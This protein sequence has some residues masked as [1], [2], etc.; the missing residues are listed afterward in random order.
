MRGKH[1]N[2]VRIIEALISNGEMSFEQLT[3][4]CGVE[5]DYIHIKTLK[6][7][8]KEL[9][10]EKYIVS[11]N[12]RYRLNK[13]RFLVNNFGIN[14]VWK[15][16]LNC[17]I[18]SG[19]IECYKKIRDFVKPQLQ[20]DLF[21]D[22]SLLRFKENI[23]ENIKILNDDEQKIYL[24]KKAILQE[25]ELQMIYKGKLLQMLPLCIVTSRDGYRN[26]VFGVRRREQE[27]M[28]SLPEIHNLKFLKKK[29]I[30]NKEMHL[31]KIK[32]SWDID[33]SDPVHVKV[34][35]RKDYDK[36]GNLEKQLRKYFGK[37]EVCR[38]NQSIFEGTVSGISDFKTWIREHMDACCIL[39]PEKIKKELIDALIVKIGRYEQNGK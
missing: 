36:D 2:Q 27:V 34:L 26:Y 3:R 10:Q 9:L 29:H 8:I 24:L 6:R 17:A 11:N 4:E 23:I 19:E 30:C 21:C 25:S 38:E 20:E 7:Y 31:E 33:I 32:N 5:A 16:L 35:L 22:E 12:K 18:E 14:E 37:A 13:E 15:K 39:E 28:L 1:L